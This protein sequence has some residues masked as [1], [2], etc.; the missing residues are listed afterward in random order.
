MLGVKPTRYEPVSA[1]Y[2]DT[3]CTQKEVENEKD[4][5]KKKKKKKGEAE[6]EEETDEST[7]DWWS[8]YFASIETH[9][10]VRALYSH[11]LLT[12]GWWVSLY[13]IHKLP[14]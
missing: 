8:K 4:K 9:M 5:R 11:L 7:L 13:E 1:F 3:L 6:E 10:E 2:F 12:C 14:D